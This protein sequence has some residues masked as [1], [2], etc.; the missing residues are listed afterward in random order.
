M[1][2][3]FRSGGRLGV[4]H[5]GDNRYSATV[6]LPDDADGRRARECPGAT[7][8]PGFFKVKPGT[9]I[10]GQ[11]TAY[12]PYC[13]H[14]GKPDVFAT[15][16][17]VRYARDLVKREAVEGARRLVRDALGLDTSGRRQLTTGLIAI[18][19]EMKSSPSPFV[20]PPLHEDLR[21]D[22]V[23]PQ[24]G[25]DQSVYGLATWC[26]DCGADI[27]LTH[28]EAEFAVLARIIADVDRR[29]DALGLR[30]AVKDL[31]NCLE[32]VISIHE[33]VLRIFA[34]RVLARHGAAADEIETKLK[35]VGNGFQNVDR[36]SEFFA[37]CLSISLISSSED[38]AALRR[39][40][41]KRHPIT[42]NLGVIDRKYLEQSQVSGREGK[43]IRV[44]ASEITAAIDACMRAFK[45]L[46]LHLEGAIA[47]SHQGR[48]AMKT[49]DEDVKASPTSAALEGHAQLDRS[50]LLHVA[51]RCHED[52]FQSFD[53][54]ELATAF[55][56]TPKD[57]AL[58]ARWLEEQGYMV[59]HEG[60]EGMSVSPTVAG[61]L[62]A[63]TLT[64]TLANSVI[65]R[66]RANLPSDS[67]TMRLGEIARATALPLGLA[68]VQVK[69]WADDGLLSFRD[70]TWPIDQALIF[71]VQESLRRSIA[72]T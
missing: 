65:D 37:E 70:N 47:E 46:Q 35:R 66:L 27:F 69:S 22:V 43:E 40:F 14:R 51:S 39:T 48:I 4:R 50:L 24:C 15:K 38:T 23:C 68:Y 45:S 56:S 57:I 9:G 17:Q 28:V 19:M 2:R 59:V 18:R 34:R 10:I 54:A 61:L 7:C 63:W 21:R 31:E 20:H 26:A 29:R 44:T 33:A 36:A 67:V 64:E 41:Q 30:V 25:L 16:Q 3:L 71:G 12:C 32:D 6:T 8:S 58:S 42:H 13:G 52:V 1:T 62:H 49:D 11:T 5:L 60:T 72:T 55:S 53:R